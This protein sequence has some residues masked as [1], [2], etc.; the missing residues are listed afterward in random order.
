MVLLRLLL[1]LAGEIGAED[2]P[3]LFFLVFFLDDPGD[4]DDTSG[5]PSGTLSSMLP[6]RT[7]FLLFFFTLAA[8]GLSLAAAVASSVA[9]FFFFLALFGSSDN[10]VDVD[11]G[12]AVAAIAASA[13][14]AMALLLLLLSSS[15]AAAVVAAAVAVAAPANDADALE[16]LE[17]L[18]ECCR[19]LLRS[20][21]NAAL[22]DID[23]TAAAAGFD[24][25]TTG[26]TSMPADAVVIET[27][28]VEKA[29]FFFLDSAAA[30]FRLRDRLRGITEGSALA[31]ALAFVLA[32]VPFPSMLPCC[33][34][35]LVQYC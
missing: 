4:G 20:F 15:A 5:D 35:L 22:I 18:L 29:A 13:S 11:D 1:F 19:R 21:F 14:S 10:N 6:L 8:P 23:G 2:P 32:L 12:F 27:D 16:G 31:L 9:V 7:A 28:A 25:A 34:Y 26:A 3:L 24:S 17:S 33:I 30:A